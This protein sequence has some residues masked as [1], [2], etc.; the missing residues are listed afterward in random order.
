[1]ERVGIELEFPSHSWW[2]CGTDSPSGLG[3]EID[4]LAIGGVVLEADMDE[5]TILQN[6]ER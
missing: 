4:F 1:M 6:Q 2:D 5:A 3:G